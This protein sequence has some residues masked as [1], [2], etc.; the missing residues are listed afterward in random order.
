MIRLK[1]YVALLIVPLL[2]SVQI[3][4]RDIRQSRTAFTQG[5]RKGVDKDFNAA[6]ELFNRAIELDSLYSEAYL[7]RGLARLELERFEDAI[8]DFRQIIHLN[9]DFSSQ[10]NYF[11]GIAMLSIDR[12]LDALIHFNEAVRLDPNFSSF[13]HRGKAFFYLNRYDE[14][15]QD[16]N[17]SDRLNPGNPEVYY[18]RAKTYT[19]KGLYNKALEN[20]LIAKDNFTG[21]PEFHYY[22]GVI[23]QN[24]N[25]FEEAAIHLRIVEEAFGKHIQPIYSE[26]NDLPDDDDDDSSGYTPDSE[27]HDLHKQDSAKSPS[28][29][30]EIDELNE[31]MYDLD[32]QAV[33]L[34]GIGV[35]MASYASTHELLENAVRYQKRFGHPVFIQVATVNNVKRYRLIIG[36][37]ESR[38]EALILRGRLRD[39]GFIDS[40]IVRYP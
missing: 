39:Q 36:V 32:F 9:R 27:E 13:F 1:L 28:D 6:H 22:Y 30:E 16:F 33:L 38:D 20:I 11:S 15:L 23:L 37:F 29:K 3:T 24:L 2:L 25:L 17:V 5:I 14:A 31:G 34:R 40:F 18:Y 35:Q 4:D 26:E 10:A 12:Y 21:N 8:E 19:S 7:Y